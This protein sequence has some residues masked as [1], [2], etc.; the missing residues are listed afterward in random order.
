MSL[1]SPALAGSTTSTTW[2]APKWGSVE[3]MA[4]ETFF[5]DTMAPIFQDMFFNIMDQEILV[6]KTIGLLQHY[7]Q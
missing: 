6:L 2:E 3:G 1:I 5:K 4:I 7:L